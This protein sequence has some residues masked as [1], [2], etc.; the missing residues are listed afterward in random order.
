MFSKN[1]VQYFTCPC[2]IV[3]TDAINGAEAGSDLY[4]EQYYSFW[5]IGDANSPARINKTK[6]FDKWLG[7]I[8]RYRAPGKLLDVGCAAGFLLDTAQKRGWE[9]FGVEVSPFAS[10]IAKERFG[11]KVFT[12][13]LADAAFAP[14]TFDAVTG[15]DV[16]E[17]MAAPIE[18]LREAARVLKPGGIIALSTADSASASCA[19]MGKSWPHFKT[20]HLCYFSP[21]TIAGALQQCGFTVRMVRPAGKFLSLE[22][23]K[24]HLET[25]PVPLLGALSKLLYAVTPAQM[26]RRPFAVCTGEM[27]VIGMK[28]E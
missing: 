5:G 7:W 26:R 19:I 15:F 22:Y 20:E 24:S 12:G 4:G 16:I 14:G 3:Y 10:A 9:P 11:D 2:G 21:K 8:E 27:V 1:A 25:Y 17:H 23:I 13:L 6:S 28:N 18:F